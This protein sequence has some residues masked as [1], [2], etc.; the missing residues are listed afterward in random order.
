MN[1]KYTHTFDPKTQRCI[2]C[3]RSR[4]NGAWPSGTWL[5]NRRLTIQLA[6]LKEDVGGIREEIQEEA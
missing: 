2:F 4:L 3:G 1:C 5:Q 6:Q